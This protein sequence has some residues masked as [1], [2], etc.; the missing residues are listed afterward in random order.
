MQQ[1]SVQRC[2]ILT[3][4]FVPPALVNWEVLS[5]RKWAADTCDNMRPQGSETVLGQFGTG[6]FTMSKNHLPPQKR[7]FVRGPC[8]VPNCPLPNC[9]VWNCPVLNCPVPN[10][11]GAKLCYNLWDSGLKVCKLDGAQFVKLEPESSWANKEED[12]NGRESTK[13]DTILTTE[14]AQNWRK[15]K[16]WIGRRKWRGDEVDREKWGWTKRRGSLY[17]D[18]TF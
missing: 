5:R 7:C 4:F 1:A 10:C 18:D 15:T 3:W 8:P 11:P 14:R 13:V 6:Q 17:A 16:D 12:E 9:P 2:T